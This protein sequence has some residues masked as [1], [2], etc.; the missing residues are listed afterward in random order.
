MNYKNVVKGYA[1]FLRLSIQILK[2][3]DDK[4]K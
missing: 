3:L 4:N 1:L 2:I